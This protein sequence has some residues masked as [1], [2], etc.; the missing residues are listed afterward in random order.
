MDKVKGILIRDSDGFGERN[1]WCRWKDVEQ[2]KILSKW[3]YNQIMIENKRW[4]CPCCGAED[5]CEDWCKFE[6][7]IK[8][9]EG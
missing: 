2:L 1:E 9:W 5:N 3:V 6:E 7:W 8:T 4:N